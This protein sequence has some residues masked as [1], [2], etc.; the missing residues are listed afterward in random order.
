[1]ARSYFA[2]RRDLLRRVTYLN[3]LGRSHPRL[4][5]DDSLVVY[6]KNGGEVIFVGT[7]SVAS[8]QDQES[9][10]GGAIQVATFSSVEEFSEPR[11]LP[12]LAGSLEKVYRFLRPELHFKRVIVKLS[13]PDFYTIVKNEID[14]YRSMFRYLFTALPIELQA[15]FVRRN[16]T[17]FPLSRKGELTDYRPICPI[18]VAYYQTNIV[19]SFGLLQRLSSQFDRLR[20][21]SG[22][23][24]LESLYFTDGDGQN[25]IDLGQTAQRTAALLES[26]PLFARGAQNATLIE[27]AQKQNQFPED[28]SGGTRTSLRKWTDPIF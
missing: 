27:E 18:I 23:P 26:N 8:V 10:E 12:V 14:L 13:R 2:I 5:T 20:G 4:A 19:D 16:I 7:S 11:L 21:I 15:D 22:V 3:H 24:P 1:M 17:S 25:E 6:E 28:A 9:S